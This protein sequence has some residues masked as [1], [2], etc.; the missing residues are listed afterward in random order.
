M[1]ST[2]E[3]PAGD[4]GIAVASVGAGAET[5]ALINKAKTAC[6]KIRDKQTLQVA[7][8][9]SIG[10]GA[11]SLIGGGLNLAGQIKNSS[12]LKKAK[13]EHA[14][15]S[16]AREDA[17]IKE[18]NNADMGAA[19]GSLPETMKG[20][21]MANYKSKA[22]I[23]RDMDSLLDDQVELAAQILDAHDSIEGCSSD[24]ITF[25]ETS[26]KFAPIA[27]TTCTSDKPVLYGSTLGNLIATY[28]DNSRLAVDM[29]SWT[30][31]DDAY[32]KYLQDADYNRG[33]NYALAD[34][35][36]K[37]KLAHQEAK[38]IGKLGSGV[39][40]MI[41]SGVAAVGG[42]AS[43]AAGVVGMLEV[44]KLFKEIDECVNAVR[45]IQ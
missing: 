29:A 26:V 34:A 17:F 41:T 21:V 6:G 1:A 20:A 37:S 12:D 42:L 24:D 30:W 45:A 18:G 10:G 40:G 36:V 16:I 13:E 35:E 27:S 43:G 44:D 28:N 38:G 2:Y 31:D 14:K 11:A 39:G 25:T 19:L 22:D 8:G 33:K 4:V 23:D 32:A 7:L 15:A 9:F 3:A 5:W